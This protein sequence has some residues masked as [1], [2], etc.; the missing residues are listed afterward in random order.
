MPRIHRK[1]QE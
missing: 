1:K